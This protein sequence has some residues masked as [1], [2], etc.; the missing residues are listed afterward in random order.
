MIA[1]L[2]SVAWSPSPKI[3]LLANRFRVGRSKISASETDSQDRR[4]VIPRK[5]GRID[6]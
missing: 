5:K 4:Q 6:L 1:S 3:S 2:V